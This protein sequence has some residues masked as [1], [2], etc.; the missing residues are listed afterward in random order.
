M[1][2]HQAWIEVRMLRSNHSHA[3][4]RFLHDDCKDEPSV[5]LA[6]FRSRKHSCLELRDLIIGIVRHTPLGARCLHLRLIGFEH[7]IEVDP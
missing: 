7:D 2:L 1:A 5:N 3:S 4:G 6:F